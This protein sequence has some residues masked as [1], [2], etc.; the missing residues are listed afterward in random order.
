MV[1]YTAFNLTADAVYHPLD[2]ETPPPSY[3]ESET[4][5]LTQDTLSAGEVADLNISQVDN[6]I[7]EPLAEN[8]PPPVDDG[9][10][11]PFNEPDPLQ[12]R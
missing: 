12:E 9:G 2:D 10:P 8:E 4:V 11:Y 6:D 7:H 1:I 3:T 5:V